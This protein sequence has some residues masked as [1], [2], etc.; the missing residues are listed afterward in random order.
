[1]ESS[2]TQLLIDAF[3]QSLPTLINFLVVVITISVGVILRTIH[4]KINLAK[5]NEQLSMLA[6]YAEIAVKAAEQSIANGKGAEK[7]EYASSFLA[8]IAKNHGLGSISEPMIR[9]I[10]E[11]AVFAV[12]SDAADKLPV[13]VA[14]DSSSEESSVKNSSSSF[15]GTRRRVDLI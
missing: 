14:S 10:L 11:A 12:K 4:A 3:K 8:N 7:M 15:T 2:S 1:M 9:T 5:N 13:I 6:Q